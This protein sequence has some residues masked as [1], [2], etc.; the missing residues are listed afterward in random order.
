MLSTTGPGR[1]P[2]LLTQ[3]RAL[4]REQRATA[5]GACVGARVRCAWRGW[6]DRAAAPRGSAVHRWRMPRADPG[7]RCGTTL[8][9]MRTLEDAPLLQP[10][11]LHDVSGR[12][13]RAAR[14]TKVLR[15][16][17]FRLALGAVPAAVPHAAH[18]RLT[19]DVSHALRSD[20]ARAAPAA[21]TN[22]PAK[23]PDPQRAAS[24]RRSRGESA[25]VRTTASRR[26]NRRAETSP[27]AMSPPRRSRRS[28]GRRQ[29]RIRQDSRLALP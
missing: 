12:R 16:G 11:L 9:V 25:G 3:R 2:R 22:R 18:Y 4:R 1:G 5:R 14:F 29:D 17:S 8:R 24:A 27:P 10:F 19:G 15:P 7:G 6:G 20:P 23:R 13:E 26:G 21:R 28:A